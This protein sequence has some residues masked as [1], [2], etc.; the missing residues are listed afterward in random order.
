[1][2]E[3]GPNLKKLIIRKMSKDAIPDGGGFADGI[4]FLRGDIGA[5][6]RKA[7]AE[8]RPMLQQAVDAGFGGTIEDAAAEVLRQID[9]RQG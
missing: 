6:F 3:I 8:I 4:D 9:D 2:N 7:E 5:A 1:M